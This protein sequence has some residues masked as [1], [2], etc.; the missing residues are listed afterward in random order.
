M[1]AVSRAL[2]C[3]DIGVLLAQQ[4]KSPGFHCSGLYDDEAELIAG[5]AYEK[6]IDLFGYRFERLS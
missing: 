6:D 1:E 2:S 5:N 3:P 4:A